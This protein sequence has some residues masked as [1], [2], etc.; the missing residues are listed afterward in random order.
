[1]AVRLSDGREDSGFTL[2]NF[3]GGRVAA[4]DF[5][6]FGESRDGET[7]SPGTDAF[8]TFVRKREAEH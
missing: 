8:A 4:Y 3:P 5:A 6:Q 1:V 2:D 7:P